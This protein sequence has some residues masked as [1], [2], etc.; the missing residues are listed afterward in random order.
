MMLGVPPP[1]MA[2]LV[3]P[4]LLPPWG[5]WAGE[6]A[7]MALVGA[8]FV[9]LLAVA[10][11]WQR[12]SA[13]PVEFTRKFVHF[14]GGLVIAVF[15][16]AFSTH[17]T[18]LLLGAGM[19][20]IFFAA[21]R[22]G[23]LA[24]VTGVERRSAGELWYPVGVY[25]LFVVARHQPAFWLIALSSLIL[26]DTA[27]AL[28]GRAYGRHAFFAAQD[29]KSVEGSAAFFLV[30]FLGVHLTLLLLTGVG[31]GASV[32]VAFQIALLVTTCEA[33]SLGGN[34]NLV[35]PLATYYLLVKMTSKPAGVI[36]LQLAAQLG[37]LLT[38]LLLAWRT[39]ALSPAG[40]LAAHL[41]IYAA[42]SL[43][44][45][46]WSVAPALALAGFVLLDRRARRDGG[47]HQV[48]AVFWVSI[49]GVALIFIDNT[50][51]TLV[52]RPHP[53]GSGHPFAVPYVGALAAPLGIMVYQYLR[54]ERAAWSRS[55]TL[56][57]SAALSWL[58]VV[59]IGL[60]ALGRFTDSRAL[61]IT[62]AMCAIALPLYLLGRRVARRRTESA[63]FRL[64]ALAVAL[65]ALTCT[66]VHL[67]W[68]GLFP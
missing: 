15:P 62:A 33:V 34:D 21:R 45:P 59:P 39:R 12:R 20:V 11:L 44:G 3:S 29:R 7:R 37:I 28:L 16:W 13:P 47:R 52:P 60:A 61:A 65:A 17:W 46:A 53:L 67:R 5:T 55:V 57:A 66:L 38:M 48:R 22:L 26:S 32:L 36:A 58:L 24:S 54:L 63:D 18:V 14:G 9:A 40:A 41:A 25:L 27:A 64:Q 23:L 6:L 19:L 1:G 31:R 30:T 49:V 43:G 4:P 8:A 68:I 2:L 10:E 42:F 50:F 35:V 51:A 56:V